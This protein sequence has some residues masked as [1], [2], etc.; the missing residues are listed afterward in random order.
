[1]DEALCF[2]W[3][4]GIRHRIDEGRYTIRFTPRRPGS[5][6]SAVNLRRVR[7]LR[8]AGRMRP[9]GL[10]VFQERDRKKAGLYSFE[11]RRQIKL[12]PR[13]ERRLRAKKR[14]WA[15]FSVQAPWYQSTAAF[16]IT[17]AKLEVTRLRRL[18]ALIA[19]SAQGRRVG[20]PAQERP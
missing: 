8:K 12:P 19:S 3:I 4:D 11:Q 7:A 14:A 9:A 13:F 16:W 17:S 10:K 20:P 6:W 5:A 1:V 18:A 2:G 15:Y